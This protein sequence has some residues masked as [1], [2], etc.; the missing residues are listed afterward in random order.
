MTQVKYMVCESS[1]KKVVTKKGGGCQR[2]LVPLPLNPA[3][4]MT[5]FEREN[6]GKRC[7]GSSG[8]TQEM[9]GKLS[10]SPSWK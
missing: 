9:A 6:M 10:L 5:C 8:S 4:L 7:W 1:L 3:T 2:G